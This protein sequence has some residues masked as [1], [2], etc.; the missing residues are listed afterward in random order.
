MGGLRWPHDQQDG[1]RF[2][3]RASQSPRAAEAQQDDLARR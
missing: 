1:A 3:F 2:M